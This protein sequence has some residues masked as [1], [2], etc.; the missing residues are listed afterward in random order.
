[1]QHHKYNVHVK[2]ETDFLQFI[3]YHITKCVQEREG[4]GKGS[5]AAVQKCTLLWA[6]EVIWFMVVVY[7]A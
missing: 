2:Q 1:M 5:N 6:P 4:G 7:R 3:V